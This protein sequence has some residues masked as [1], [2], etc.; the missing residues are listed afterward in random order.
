MRR[1]YDVPQSC[2]PVD[3]RF[4]LAR[5]IANVHC[6]EPK[7]RGFASFVAQFLISINVFR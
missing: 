4:N 7:T 2:R 3:Q 5:E 1:L 6:A